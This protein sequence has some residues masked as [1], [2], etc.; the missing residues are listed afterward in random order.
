MNA[1]RE[2][3]VNTLNAVLA[4]MEREMQTEPIRPDRVAA[5]AQAI[6]AL[7]PLVLSSYSINELREMNG[8]SEIPD[9]AADKKLLM[10]DYFICGGDRI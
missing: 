1:N 9:P 6:S 10:K 3:A 8:L 5:L 2:N 4:S 7:Y